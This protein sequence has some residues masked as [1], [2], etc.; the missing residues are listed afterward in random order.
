MLSLET[1]LDDLRALLVPSLKENEMN[2]SL[3]KILE[4][5]HPAV[6][7][8]FAKDFFCKTAE[9][10]VIFSDLLR[11]FWASKQHSI[12]TV[13]R[14]SNALDFIFIMDE[15]MKSIDQMWHVFLLY[16]KDYMDFCNKYFG[17]FLHHLLR[18]KKRMLG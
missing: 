10:E 15:E 6:I 14:E 18:W 4:Y 17:E 5:K 8:R 9:A 16:T 1:L 13:T 11:F 12:D 3:L 2:S 7:A